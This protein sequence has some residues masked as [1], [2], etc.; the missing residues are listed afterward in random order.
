MTAV[1]MVIGSEGERLIL[2][3]ARGEAPVL[4]LTTWDRR[5]ADGAKLLPDALRQV[6]WVARRCHDNQAP[7]PLEVA[8]DSPRGEDE[9]RALRWALDR[10]LAAGDVGVLAAARTELGI[11][12]EAFWLSDRGRR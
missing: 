3:V 6:S 11:G 9:D 1:E 5:V 4:H 12:L 10:A 7:D 8:G 2:D